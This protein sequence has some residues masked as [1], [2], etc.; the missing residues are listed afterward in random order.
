MRVPAEKI[1]ADIQ[2]F[3]KKNNRVPMKSE[4]YNEHAARAR[5]GTWNR[6]I[7]AAGLTPVESKFSAKHIAKDGHICD[8]VSELIIDNWLFKKGIPHIRNVFYP[9]DEGFTVD[10]WVNGYWVEFF[11]LSGKLKKY[12]HLKARKIALAANFNLKLIEL[13]PKD[14]F[15]TFLIHKRLSF[16]IDGIANNQQSL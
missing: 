9:G 6:S 4:Y 11:G 16:L 5:F 15:P 8:S 12:D 2:S 3:Y 7:L 13:Y 10:F 14:L 1:I